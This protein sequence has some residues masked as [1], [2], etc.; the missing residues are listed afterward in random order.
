MKN[1][2]QLLSG[3]IIFVFFGCSTSDQ[4]SEEITKA[5]ELIL[6]VLNANHLY[7]KHYRFSIR[8]TLETIYIQCV[9]KKRQEF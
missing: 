7:Y 5:D 4:Y 6:N 3:L 9:S 2:K 1:L 8:K